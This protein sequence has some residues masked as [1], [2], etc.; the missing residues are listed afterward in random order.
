VSTPRGARTGAPLGQSAV[1]TV[2]LGAR[3]RVR[4]GTVRVQMECSRSRS[5]DAIADVRAPLARMFI[6][7]TGRVGGVWQ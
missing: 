3:D 2:D 6:C 7:S 1:I 5:I 4:Q